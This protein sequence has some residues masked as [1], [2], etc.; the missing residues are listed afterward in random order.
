MPMLS[1]Q[2]LADLTL[3]L[4]WGISE[5]EKKKKKIQLTTPGSVVFFDL[6]VSIDFSESSK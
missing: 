4:G 5:E 6:L 2:F 3:R 1:S